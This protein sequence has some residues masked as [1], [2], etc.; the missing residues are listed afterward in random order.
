MGMQMSI[1]KKLSTA[2]QGGVREAAEVVIDSNSLRILGQ[3][4]YECEQDIAKSK[5]RLAA[6]IAEK[7]QVKR[8]LDA[9][10]ENISNYEKEVMQLLDSD[11][12]G[13]AT[14]VAQKIAEI[15]PKILQKQGHLEKLKS[16][17][18]AL[19]SS[20]KKTVLGLDNF[21]SEYKMA[22]ATENL[23]K[24]QAT[25]SDSSNPDSRFNDMKESL[26]RIQEKQQES[27]DR[28]DA[29][30]Q[31]EAALSIDPLNSKDINVL[32]AEDII[33]RIKSQNKVV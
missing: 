16:H 9:L 21:K 26:E 25:F 14:E 7:I 23:Q 11:D 24:A 18:M 13:K 22:K 29:M 6:I 3:E 28:I 20:L 17:E 4:I 32:S 2:L 8:G 12:K 27:T 1:L 33:Q 5:Q 19:Q 30:D 10:I 15:E 31:V